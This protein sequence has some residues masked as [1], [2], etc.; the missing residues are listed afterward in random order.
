MPSS[1]TESRDGSVRSPDRCAQSAAWPSAR[2]GRPARPA[3]R[4]WQTHSVRRSPATG[5]SRR[6]TG[7]A[8]L[9]ASSASGP[10]SLQLRNL[11]QNRILRQRNI[12]R[13]RR[14]RWPAARVPGI[15]SS[16]C[17]S[18]RRALRTRPAPLRNRARLPRC[19]RA[20]RARPEPRGD[21]DT[22]PPDSRNPCFAFVCSVPADRSA[23]LPSSSRSS[24]ADCPGSAAASRETYRW[25]DRNSSAADT[26]LPPRAA[27]AQTTG[28]PAPPASCAPGFAPPRSRC[29]RCAQS[30]PAGRAAAHWLRPRPAAAPAASGPSLALV[31][32]NAEASATCTPPSS[33]AGALLWS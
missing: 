21:P 15:R 18:A 24:R 7:W 9:P 16:S 32:R 8:E 33:A 3:T 1:E 6:A 5:S 26:C 20:S 14:Q 31:C 25:R 4:E 27:L 29:S 23:T 2:P 10:G 12:R 30:H 22:R 13:C 28:S 19:A 11:R 17:G